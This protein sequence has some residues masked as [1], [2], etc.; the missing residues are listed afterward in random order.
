MKQTNFREAQ[1][2]VEES[3]K[4]DQ[5]SLSGPGS[6]VVNASEVTNLIKETIKQY[7]IKSILD[8][9]CGDW[10][11]F[12]HIELKDIEYQGWDADMDMIIQNQFNHGESNINFYVNDIVQDNYPDVD[13]I[14]CRD[15]LF[16]MPMSLANHIIS[17]AKSACKYFIS[18]SFRDV[19]VNTGIPN[20]LNWGYYSINLNKNPFNLF[21]NEIKF[22]REMLGASRDG[23]T[24]SPKRYICLYDFFNFQKKFSEQN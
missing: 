6:S 17:K 11:W 8:L 1:L 22:Q 21:D 2:F 13:L 18:T 24:L 12:Q 20:G 10:N 16:H 14:I 23:I 4:L 19:D 9:G 5:E 7:N 3:R 15:V